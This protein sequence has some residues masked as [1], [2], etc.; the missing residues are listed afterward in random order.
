MTQNDV[1]LTLR[2]NQLGFTESACYDLLRLQM[3]ANQ[4]QMVHKEYV[5]FVDLASRITAV[6]DL[7]RYKLLTR[8]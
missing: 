7:C 1:L 6:L 4:V 3:C 8:L 2:I 5:S